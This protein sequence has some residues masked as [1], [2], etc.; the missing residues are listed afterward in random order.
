M[1][2]KIHSRLCN[3]LRRASRV[4]AFAV[5]VVGAA[6]LAGRL[7]NIHFLVAIGSD[8]NVLMKANTALCLVLCG[9]A[10]QLLALSDVRPLRRQIGSAMG[11]IV[12]LVGV[13]TLLEH[14]TGWDIGIDQMLVREA[15]GEVATTSPGRMGPPA[16]TSFALLGTALIL[17]DVRTRRRGSVP[18]QI[19][20]LIVGGIVL[21]PTLG[22]TYGV[23]R[24]Y[25]I[26]HI[27]GIALDSALCL[28]GLSVATLFMRPDRGL[29]GVICAPNTGGVLA[30]MLIPPA[31]VV[32]FLLG[33]LRVIGERRGL[34]ST[35]EG[36]A[37]FVMAIIIM[38][39]VMIWWAAKISG[40]IAVARDRAEDIED[41]LNRR[42]VDILEAISQ[43]FM[44]L[45]KDWRFT[46]LNRRGEQFLGRKREEVFGKSIT[47]VLPHLIS[48]QFMDD[49]RQAALKQTP[50]QG[51]YPDHIKERWYEDYIVPTAHGV[52]VFFQ[53]I[54]ERRQR[55]EE[56]KLL[57]D[58]ERAA[59]SEA[60]H[61][62][63][64]KDEFLATL[65]HELRTP[66][67][68]ILGWAQLLTDR[69]QVP[70]RI[71]EG[72][73]AIR[74]N[75]KTQAQLIE[76]LLDMSRIV[77]GKIRVDVQRIEPGDAM[78]AAAEAVQAA[79]DA[80]G[81][82]LVKVLDPNSGVV[83]ADAN[84]L[85]QIVWNL[86]S[87]AIRFTPR[88]GRVQ[89]T[90]RRVESHAEIE[91]SD[92]G[93]GIAPDF[94]PHVFER[95]KQG[96]AST[97]RQHGGLGLGLAIVRHLTELHGG[98]VSAES[99][100]L[101]KGAKF[102]VRLPVT[103]VGSAQDDGPKTLPTPA[104]RVTLSGLSVVVV[105][106]EADARALLRRVLEDA[107]AKV[108][109]ASSAAEAMEVLQTQES[110]VLI[111][112]IGMP[113]EDGYELLR[114][115]RSSQGAKARR[116]PAVALTAFARPEDR[117]RAML[118][119]F[120]IHMAKPV[121]PAELTAVVANLAGEAHDGEP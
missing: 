58:A 51:E 109:S 114:K 38:A 72:L 33:W 87:N 85:Q 105:D 20:A 78:E 64:M 54:T 79:A 83:L 73:L 107:G 110:D 15:P 102:I 74:R 101:G 116:I 97:T 104:K 27:T 55:E 82:R 12:A 34:Y 23:T 57:L 108:L 66:L 30:R 95:F 80:K 96:D 17:I 117:K 32:P 77:S 121:D 68:A 120:Q 28:I 50:H 31:L 65:S 63:R 46:Y 26:A 48:S 84:R 10:V 6:N 52:S 47:D 75:A 99:E 24:F 88:G 22:Y 112:D 42:I 94:L 39:M 4:I 1:E 103:A 81:V 100:G 40:L 11:V 115:L 16:S 2:T 60:Q 106:D 37:M 56:R 119:G 29:M 35:A 53:D 91:V 13:L 14:F 5:V 18:S 86:L 92:T 9:I 111:S 71:H 90:L 8:S 113:H 67:N 93:Q 44:S 36:T 69:E 43:G 59:R 61:A 62:S 21:V 19:M 25:L 70:E 98:T 3:N 41:E 7:F 76:D 118:S 89:M 45:D 49:L